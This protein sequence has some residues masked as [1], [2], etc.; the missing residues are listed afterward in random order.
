[1][2]ESRSIAAAPAEEHPGFTT[3]LGFIAMCVGMFMAILDIQVVASSLPAMAEA[4]AI[5]EDK[6]SW[7]QTSYL[8]AEIIAIPL[9]GFLT[10]ALSVR[11]LFAGA[12]LAFTLA[13]IGC[14]MSGNFAELIVLR[15]VQGFCGGALIP[16][17][18]TTIFVLFEGKREA[19][20]TTVAGSF[21]MVAPTLGPALGGL[22]TETYSWHAIFL[23]NVLPGIAVTAV[24]AAVLRV[25]EPQWNLLRKIDYVTVILAAI[26]LASLELVLKEGPKH[27]WSGG[28][29]WLL[30]SVCAVSMALT[31]QQC[32]SRKEPFVNLRRFSDLSF[33]CGCIL[34]FVLGLGLYGATYMTPLFLGFVRGHNALEIGKIMIVAGAAQLLAAPLAA[35][36]ETRMDAR[37]LA[38]AGFALFAAGL[39]MNGFEHPR[40]DFNEFF[41][42]QVLRGFAIMFCLLPATRLALDGWPREE[43]SDA[44]ALFNLMR[45]LGGAIGIALVDTV[46][47]QR[48]PGHADALVAEL[49]AGHRAAAQFV[50]L[51]LNYFHEKAIGPVDEFT[52]MLVEPLVRK[53]GVTL[54]FNEAW[55]LTGLIFVLSLPALLLAG[56]KRPKRSKSPAS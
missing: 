4:L 38:F 8:I 37:K 45:N 35:Y 55:L 13:S 12:T 17:V 39:I 27:H 51:P 16:I 42:P 52:K 44:S 25:G 32:L 14:A 36:L 18:F 23:I 26:F 34:S 24:V 3:W 48:T 6:L 33:T 1:M 28:Y 50:G 29:V 11:W 15:T 41:W 2:Q 53:A 31:I 54:S 43:L 21:A 56:A 19:L 20:A 7:I 10:R 22:L 5:P 47:E 40:W 49:Q 30:L 46:L 9:T